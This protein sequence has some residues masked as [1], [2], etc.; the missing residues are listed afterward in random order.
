MGKRI[1][2]PGA[3]GLSPSIDISAIS[4]NSKSRIFLTTLGATVVVGLKGP[5]ERKVAE[6]V[7]SDEEGVT[8]GFF[9]VDE[10]FI[11]ASVSNCRPEPDGVNSCCGGHSGRTCRMRFETH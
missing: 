10:S 3:V 4:T 7:V 8:M 5:A 2:Q 6:E 1:G 9:A 11:A